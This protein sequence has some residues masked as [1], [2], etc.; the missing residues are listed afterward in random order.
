MIFDIDE[1]V[2]Y[3]KMLSKTDPMFKKSFDHYNE[4]WDTIMKTV[5]K[6]VIEDPVSLYIFG[7]SLHSFTEL[8]MMKQL[9]AMGMKKEEAVDICEHLRAVAQLFGQQSVMQVEEK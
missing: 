8:A 6:M 2:R 9:T 7:L 3:S 4:L 5:R 1:L